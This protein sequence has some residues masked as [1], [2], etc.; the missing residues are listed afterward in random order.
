MQSLRLEEVWPEK[1]GKELA[2]MAMEGLISHP[3]EFGLLLVD[4][5]VME[6]F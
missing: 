3:K 2:I 5:R 4:V 1:R 6:G